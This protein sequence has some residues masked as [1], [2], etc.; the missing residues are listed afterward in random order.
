MTIDDMITTSARMV[1]RNRRRYRTVIIAI[2][3][4][5]VG[6]VLIRTLGQSV[7]GRVAGDLELIGEATVLTAWWEDRKTPLHLGEFLL[8]DAARLSE[9]PHVVIVAPYEGQRRR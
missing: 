5:T 9:L 3:L 4:G 2:A 1:Y 7:Q 8:R 6:F